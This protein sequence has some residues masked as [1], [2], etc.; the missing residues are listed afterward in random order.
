MWL[1]GA[2]AIVLE[3]DD[4]SDAHELWWVGARKGD[5]DYFDYLSKEPAPIYWV[6]GTGNVCSCFSPP[7]SSLG[8]YMAL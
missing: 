7:Q 5:Q 1:T 3:L 6:D 2:I 4:L 8:R